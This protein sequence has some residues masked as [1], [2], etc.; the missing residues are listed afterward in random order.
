[1]P[2]LDVGDGHQLYYQLQGDISVAVPLLFV[3]GGPGA[4]VRPENKRLFSQLR[5]PVIYFD[6]RGCGNSKFDERLAANT[7]AHLIED[8]ETLRRALAIEKLILVGGSWGST[9]SLLYAIH[10][11]QRVSRLLL[12]GIFLCRQQELDWFYL[13][14]ANHIYPEEYERF[15]A[16][17]DTP[18]S[19]VT[20][21]FNH[22]SS[23]SLQQRKAAAVSWARWEAV[24]SFL[25]ADEQKIAEFTDPEISL[26]MALLASYYFENKG[27]IAENYILRHCE[28]MR[29]I[30]VNIVHGRLDTICPCVSAWQLANQLEQAQL[31]ISPLAAHDASEPENF[32]ALRAL[33]QA[34]EPEE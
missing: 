16:A 3:H 23:G 1:M 7:T 20:A 30:A 27:F 17:I 33:L 6:Q 13:N 15:L 11:P 31:A 34:I 4:G 21:Y 9:L 32:S 25:T 19:P 12:W 22:L 29:S 8:I 5:R 26:P 2:Y 10:Y 18:R 14:G 28:N 24:N